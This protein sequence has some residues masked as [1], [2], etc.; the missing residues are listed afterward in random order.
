MEPG[1]GKTRVAL[2]FCASKGQSGSCVVFAPPIVLNVWEKELEK[3]FPHPYRVHHIYE[4][5]HPVI[6]DGVWNFVLCSYGMALNK[7][8]QSFLRGCDF[9]VGICDEAHYIKSPSSKRSRMVISIRNNAVH[10][11]SL[12]GTPAPN[13]LLD[14]FN[15]V[16]YV[17]GEILGENKRLFWDEYAVYGGW[18]NKQVVGV[19][20]RGKLLNQLD[21]ISFIIKK[22]EAVDLPPLVFQDV[23][24]QMDDNSVRRHRECR[25]RFNKTMREAMAKGPSAAYAPQL[26]P[27][28]MEMCRIAGGF[29]SDSTIV[30]VSKLRACFDLTSLLVEEGHKVVI[31]ARFL[32][33]IAALQDVTSEKWK[34]RAITGNVSEC[35]RNEIID[36]FN[37]DSSHVQVLILQCS[38]GVGISLTGG[39]YG[40][41]YSTDYNYSSYDQAVNRIHR[42][43][44]EK[45]VTI[46]NLVS[47]GMIDEKIY[48]VLRKK[49]NEQD[50]I[51]SM[52]GE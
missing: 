33:E 24:V 31:F 16:R 35:R 12:T 49:G 7:K 25:E 27:T 46:Y 6:D 41:F 43:G 17:S 45:K 3:V 34:V 37:E 8:V 22:D 5:T 28:L 42:I 21:K 26:M 20:Q 15:P 36:M 48:N 1:T 19:R 44:Q 52:K 32:A 4:N 38:L 14:V 2:A 39:S 30:D 50:L 13:N 18:R 9:N 51:M 10:R 47:K 11:L 23:P 29:K 40:I